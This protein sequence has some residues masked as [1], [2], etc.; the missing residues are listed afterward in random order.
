MVYAQPNISTKE[1]HTLIPL[2]FWHPNRSPN[3]SQTT[4]PYNNQQKKENLQNCG[5]CCPHWI[6]LKKVKRRINTW[7]LLGN[8][9]KLW[10][11][12]VTFIPIVIGAFG[13]VTKGIIKGLEE[14]EIRGQVES[15]QTTTLLKSA[16]ILRRV[17]E[18]WDLL[19]LK[20]KWKTIS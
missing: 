3:L 6:K 11:M 8:W 19:S 5:L 12:K 16:R 14:L 13:T 10:N 7:T 18:T 2:G 17:L 1:W 4:R 15:I 20:L 9:K